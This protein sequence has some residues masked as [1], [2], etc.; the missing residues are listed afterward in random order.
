MQRN[1][2]EYLE[3]TAPR[4]P[5]KTAFAN[6]Q[7]GM[8]FQEVHQGGEKYRNLPRPERIY[9]RTG[10]YIYEETSPYDHSVLGSCIQRLL[11]CADGRRNAGIP[12]QPDL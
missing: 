7:M 11:L 8:T 1:I 5:D 12:D 6:E 10:R 4:F 3:Q 9:E 2:L